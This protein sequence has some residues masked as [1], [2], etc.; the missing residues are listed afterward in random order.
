MND[1]RLRVYWFGPYKIFSVFS[2]VCLLEIVVFV[3]ADFIYIVSAVDWIK[4]AKFI[5]NY[6]SVNILIT[7]K[8]FTYAIKFN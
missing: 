7:Y 2:I 8:I 3:Q 5:H 1:V 4:S 6:F